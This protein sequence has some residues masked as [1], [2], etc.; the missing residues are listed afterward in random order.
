MF[1]PS[2]TLNVQV[3]GGGGNEAQAVPS[4]VLDCD[5]ITQVKEKILDQAYKTASFSLRP[6][7]DSL[8]LGEPKLLASFRLLKPLKTPCM[9]NT[10]PWR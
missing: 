4:K 9:V 3:Q 8:D 1:S 10:V 6:H 7:A 2:Q 5:T